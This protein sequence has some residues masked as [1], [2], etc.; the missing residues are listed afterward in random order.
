MVK[1]KYLR[2]EELCSLVKLLSTLSMF[3]HVDCNRV[4]CV[5]SV[6]AKTRAY[7]RIYGT[8]LAWIAVGKR[9]EYLIEVISERF[10]HLPPLKKVEVIIHELL[11]IPY[12]FSGG[13]RSH[14]AYTSHGMVESVVRELSSRGLLDEALSISS[15]L[16]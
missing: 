6:G 7:A 9:P 1:L 4:Y 2:Y 14:G 11:H 13:L 5:K 16:G 12:S 10:T 8:P 15:R 3:S